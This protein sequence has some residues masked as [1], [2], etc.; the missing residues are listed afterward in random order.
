M[1]DGNVPGAGPRDEVG[2]GDEGPV[3]DEA[4]LPVD[5]GVELGGAGPGDALH[6]H[7]TL[8]LPR[9][10]QDVDAVVADV[11]QAAAEVLEVAQEELGKVAQAAHEQAEVDV[12]LE[13][14]S[15]EVLP[16]HRQDTV[17]LY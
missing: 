4:E 6:V 1:E 8:T 12:Q 2:H 10:G 17:E 7:V 5:A 13:E 9:T 3:L 11:G 14:A 15:G 16:E